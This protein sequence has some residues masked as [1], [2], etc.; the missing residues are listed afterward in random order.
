MRVVE[1]NS[2]IDGSII[3]NASYDARS[4]VTRIARDGAPDVDY[5]YV[6]GSTSLTI[7]RRVGTGAQQSSVFNDLGRLVSI[8]GLANGRAINLSYAPGGLLQSITSD[9]FTEARAYTAKKLLESITLNADATTTTIA[10]TYDNRS[11]RLTET[12]DGQTTSYKH[13]AADRLVGVHYPGDVAELYALRGDGA[14]VGKKRLLNYP[15]PLGDFDDETPEPALLE[16][17]ESYTFDTRDGLSGITNVLT[18]ST[19][20][21]VTDAAGR[22]TSMQGRAYVWDAS[23]RLL[24][25][26]FLGG[27]STYRYSADGL[28]TLTS[29]NATNRIYVWGAA[30]LVAEGLDGDPLVEHTRGV[31]LSL[32]V[33]DELH[34]H[35]GLGSVVLRVPSAGTATQTTFD[36]WGAVR[37]GAALGA[38]GDR[39]GFTGHA[40]ESTGLVY[41]EQRW[42]SPT[43]A[44]FL[45]L[46]PVQGVLS[47]PL[48]TQ[49]FS[50]A[51]AAPT[52]FTDPTGEAVPLVVIG[53]IKLIG[54]VTAAGAVGGAVIGGAST[55]YVEENASA[56]DVALG[57]GHG[58]LGGATAGFAAGAAIAAAPAVGVSSIFV[59]T[60]IAAS[61]VG[62][63]AVDATAKQ[64]VARSAEHRDEALVRE[65][66]AATAIAGV[67]AATLAVAKAGLSGRSSAPRFE[68]EPVAVTR[69][70]TGRP[71][72]LGGPSPRISTLVAAEQLELPFGP[73]RSAGLDVPEPL[74]IERVSP[75]T[76]KSRQTSN[77]MSTSKVDRFAKRMRR[78]GWDEAKDPIEIAEVDGK[79][80]ILDGHHRAAA[81][82]KA[83]LPSVP[84]RRTQVTPE[85]GQQLLDEVAAASADAANRRR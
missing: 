21:V 3:T 26:T 17:H 66:N 11:N 34:G 42:L 14:R 32:A 2:F 67:S 50:Y 13:D 8:T 15:A 6:D 59:G 9:G 44:R 49:G 43:T 52:R 10:Y 29:E 31:G 23:D 40:N 57:A 78:D 39:V 63:A 81:A 38:A 64:Y 19:S 74:L 71:Q 82:R 41:A 70:S 72:P 73:P 83:R 4:R 27:V 55:A 58:L 46:D 61:G 22:V 85:Q 48:S 65:A 77:E 47:E 36:A 20:P 45:S 69:W 62:V 18:S 7:N 75:H 12:I 60:T 25:T 53:V 84:V 51:H 68:P 30:G 28:R 54:V 35:D 76:L 16:Q 80:I 37:A 24:S 33:G 79:K 1:I 5:S 56:A